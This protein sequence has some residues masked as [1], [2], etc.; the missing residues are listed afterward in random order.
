MR[1]LSRNMTDKKELRFGVLRS[2]KNKSKYT[3]EY[4]EDMYLLKSNFEKKIISLDAQIKD[5]SDKDELLKINNELIEVNLKLNRVN[6]TLE[7]IEEEK[8]ELDIWKLDEVIHFNQKKS[9][10][11][12]D[13]A[14][15]EVPTKFF[16][17]IKNHNDKAYLKKLEEYR[18]SIKKENNLFDEIKE[19]FKH[20]CY[21]C[22]FYDEKY[23]EIHHLDG[24]HFNDIETN[25]VPAC[26]LCHRQHH[27]LWLSQYDHASLGVLDTKTL[28]QTELNH[29]LRIN[30][31]LNK[32]RDLGKD[33]ELSSIIKQLAY[34]FEKPPHAFLQDED[35]KVKSLEEYRSKN[36]VEYSATERK[37]QYN[38]LSR[39]L[40][41]IKK[42]KN[43]SLVEKKD[44]DA[45]DKF[46][47]LDSEKKNNQRQNINIDDMEIRAKHE[48]AINELL[49][50]HDD[51]F[52]KHFEKSFNN[53]V[54]SFSL[55]E[56]A[57]S[58][59]RID[60]SFYEEFKPK[61]LFLVFNSSIFSDEQIEYYKTLNYFNKE[62]WN[63]DE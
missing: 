43:L 32:D 61:N 39:A 56:L 16:G 14:E 49:D 1:F 37:E 34:N 19:K 4:I 59:T 6:E 57:V 21:F 42:T 40:L 52:E 24:D 23:L 47:D 22:D 54:E 46:I 36:L 31:V 18:E 13:I 45:Y 30:F 11:L 58:L 3:N 44:L 62:N 33:G 28:K 50:Y 55:F 5:T 51:A 15:P 48:T 8:K 60:Y 38:V 7:K 20:R 10:D 25:L 63:Y 53:D 27:L 17:L 26:T 9:D 12:C 29:I 41:V 2:K 35:V